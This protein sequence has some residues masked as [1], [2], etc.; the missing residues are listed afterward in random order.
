MA[1]QPASASAKTKSHAA[2]ASP[3]GAYRGGR[4]AQLATM[5]YVRVHKS[6]AFSFSAC[7]RA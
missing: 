1:Q 5:I 7:L 4:L 6:K 3:S 2:S